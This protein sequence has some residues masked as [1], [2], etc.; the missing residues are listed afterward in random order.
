MKSNLMHMQHWINQEISLGNTRDW[1][2]A[3][4]L[5]LARPN[6]LRTM[7]TLHPHG[8]PFPLLIP[9]LRLPANMTYN[10]AVGVVAEMARIVLRVRR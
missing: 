9:L 1:P 7:W 2:D 5:V 4:W 3:L 8:A 6:L 10:L